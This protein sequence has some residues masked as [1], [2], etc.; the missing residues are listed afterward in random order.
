MDTECEK[1]FT[2]VKEF[3]TSPLILTYPNEE[4]HLFLH[5]SVIERAISSVFVQEIDKAK[6][7]VYFVIK[8]FFLE[9]IIFIGISG[10]QRRV[11]HK[12]RGNKHKK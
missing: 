12:G 3:L 7:L 10:H 5:L 8:H 9:A 1:D 2:K 11:L 4:S 6:R